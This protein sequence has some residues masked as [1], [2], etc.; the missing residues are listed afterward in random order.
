[1]PRGSTRPSHIGP[2]L[3]KDALAIKVNGV[4]RDLAAPLPDNA[5]IAIITFDSDEGKSVFW[6][7]SSH[8]LAQAV[9]ELFPSAKIAIGPGH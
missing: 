3:A 8:I 7:T 9:Q 4:L 6:H 1:M 5:R 2:R